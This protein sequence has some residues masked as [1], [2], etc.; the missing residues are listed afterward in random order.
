MKHYPDE[1]RQ[2]NCSTTSFNI[3]N[4]DDLQQIDKEK[5]SPIKNK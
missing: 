4:Y 1:T 2:K 3:K 5:E